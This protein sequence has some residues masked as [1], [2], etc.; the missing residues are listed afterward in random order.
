[1][2]LALSIAAAACRLAGLVAARP[3]GKSLVAVVD[4]IPAGLPLFHVP[5]IPF[6]LGPARWPGS[7]LAVACLGCWRRCRSP[8][9]LPH[10]TRQPL[11]YN[12]QCLAEGLANLGGGFFQCLPGSGSLTRSAINFQAGAVTRW[13]GAFAA[14][15]VALVVVAFCT[16]RPLYS[17][18]GPGRDP[19]GHRGRADRPA[20][21]RPRRA[22]LAIRCPA[23]PGHGLVGGADRRGVF[24]PDRRGIVDPDVRAPR[25]PLAG[26]ANWWSA[27]TG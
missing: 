1:M 22:G 25:R 18:G 23:G 19:A 10:Q 13:S 4:E 20:A 16:A 2:L 17:Q 8:N 15:A 26:R 12:R 7:A 5:R 9:P 3:D 11:D 24:D 6:R 14:A 27:P 21:D